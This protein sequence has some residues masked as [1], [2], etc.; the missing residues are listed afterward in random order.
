MLG[1]LTNLSF[2]VE[3]VAREKGHQ[4]SVKAARI[5]MVALIQSIVRHLAVS[6]VP[7]LPS[8]HR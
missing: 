3:R 7:S 1:K 8:P 2:D 4:R 5:E 6:V